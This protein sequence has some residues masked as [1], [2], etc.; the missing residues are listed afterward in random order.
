MSEERKVTLRVSIVEVGDLFHL[1]YY[2]KLPDDD[3]YYL[4]SKTVSQEQ[5]ERWLW[6]IGINPLEL[7]Y[8]G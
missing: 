7:F 5:L 8:G 2:K 1:T 3:K 4:A 6:S